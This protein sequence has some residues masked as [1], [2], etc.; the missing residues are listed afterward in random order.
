MA[1]HEKNTAVG[2]APRKTKQQAALAK[3]YHEDETAWL[4][5]MSR[6]AQLGRLEELDCENLAEY[7]ESMGRRD[8]REIHNRLVILIAH[9]LKW[10]YQPAKR[11][12]S[13][14]RTIFN[15]R[16]ELEGALTRS[17]RNEAETKLDRI[18]RSAVKMAAF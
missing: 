4:F 9:L 15:Q 3:L 8:H 2:T 14:K 11:T 13:W 17:L 12:N 6:L 18:Y 5:K 7:L 16:F 10:T 1:R